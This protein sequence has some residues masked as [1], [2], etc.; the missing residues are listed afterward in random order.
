MKKQPISIVFE[1]ERTGFIAANER[2]CEL[3]LEIAVEGLKAP[4]AVQ[5]IP[6]SSEY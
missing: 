3:V 6:P 2:F 4:G 1:E 5:V